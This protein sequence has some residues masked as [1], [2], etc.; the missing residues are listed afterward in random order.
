[1]ACGRGPRS[2]LRVLRHGLE[3]GV[4]V[5]LYLCHMFASSLQGFSDFVNMQASLW[6][7][8]FYGTL[9][10]CVHANAANGTCKMCVCVCVLVHV[11]LR[12]GCVRTSW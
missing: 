2:T 3:V 6:S 5:C 10:C 7:D 12:D 1:M 8:T 11:G 9:Q 4:Y